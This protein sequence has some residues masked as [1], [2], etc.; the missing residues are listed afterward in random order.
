MSQQQHPSHGKGLEDERIENIGDSRRENPTHTDDHKHDKALDL[1]EVAGGSP[2]LTPENN[3]QVLRKIDLR[4]LPI[5]LAIY[6]LQQVDKSTLSYASVFGIIED[7]GLKGQEYSWLGSVIYLAQLVVQPL[8]A[9]IL[10]K[11]PLGKFLACTTFF[12]GVALTCM[13]PANTFAKLLVCRLF[14]GLFEAGIPPAF[15]ATTQMWYRRYEQPVRLGSWYAM[16]GV[17]NMVGSLITWG[18]AHIQSSVFAPYQIIFIFFGLITVVF[19][20]VVLAFMPDSPSR[21]KFLDEEDKLLAIERLRMNQQGMETNEWKWEHVKEALLDIKSFFWFALMFSISIPSGGITTFGPL[22]VKSF[23]FDQFKTIL[24]NIPFGAVQLVATMGGAWFA[25]YIK[26]KGPVIALLCLPA[27]A[28]CVM[29]LQIP[30]DGAHKGA[31]LAGYY[32]ISVYPGITPLIYSWSAANTAGET[33]KKVTNG[34]LL[35]GQCAGNVVGPNLYTTEEAPLYRRGLLS[36]LALFCVLVVLCGLNIAYLTLLNKKHEKTRVS[37]GKSAKV[38]DHSMY[39]VGAIQADKEENSPQQL[40]DDNAFRDMTD[41]Q[42]EDFVYRIGNAKDNFWTYTPDTE[43]IDLSRGVSEDTPLLTLQTTTNPVRLNPA[44]TAL[45]IIDMQNFFLCPALRR[46]QAES[47]PTAGEKAAQVLIDTGI[48]AA[49][50]HQIRVVWLNWGLTE[51]DLACMPPGLMR[52]FG[53]YRAVHTPDEAKFVSAP[54]S[55]VRE[56]NPSLYR[57]LG[58]D[59]GALDIGNSEVVEGGRVLMRDTWNVALYPPL[60]K[61]YT[62][63]LAIAAAT[64]GASSQTPP[65]PDAIVYKNRMSGL[66]GASTEL[67]VLLKGEGITTLLFAGVNTDQCVGGT[68]MD[69]FSKGEAWEYNCMNCWGFVTSCEALKKAQCEKL[70]KRCVFFEMPKDPTTERIENVESEVRR[71]RE[72]LDDMHS[73]LR[74]HSQTSVVP[75]AGAVASPPAPLPAQQP[76]PVPS[77]AQMLS[78]APGD[79]PTYLDS[80]SVD[81]TGPQRDVLLQNIPPENEYARPAKRKRSGFEVRCDPIADFISKGMITVEYAVSCFQTFF[82]GCDRYIPIFDPEYDTFASVRARSSILLNAICTIGSRIETKPQKADILHSELKKWINVVIQ[83]ER[84]NCLESVQALLVIACYSAER[85]LLLSFATRM[86]LD[87]SLDEAFEELT[88]RLTMKGIGGASDMANS[89]EEENMLMRKSRVWFGFFRV[90]GGKPPGIRMTGNARRC[91]LLLHHPS[92]TVLD[93]RLFSQVE[94]NV[95]RVNINE[96]LGA[97]DT[98]NR[99]DIADFVHEAKVDLDLW[100]DDW[101]RIIR[102]QTYSLEE[103]VPDDT[104]ENSAAAEEERPSLLAALRVQKCWS[105]MMLYC[106]ALRSMGVENI[107]AM[108]A[109]ERNI[110]IMAKASARQHLRLISVE[111]DFYLAKLKYAMDFVWAKCAFCFLLLL[112]LSRLMPEQRE[113]HQELLEHGTRL[114]DE[115][116]KSGSNS[117]TTGNGNV[118]L[119]ILRLSIEKYGRILQENEIGAE[120]QVSGPFWELFD[121]Q[122][123]LQSFV[124]EQFVTEWDFP[125]LNLFYFPTAWQDFFGDYSLAV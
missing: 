5:L 66:W 25:T 65:K 4:L 98:L 95:I 86:A 72:Q 27:I 56:K 79:M 36:N 82:Q 84:L 31:L 43:E 17:V 120:D 45:V 64:S 91:R 54:A 118:Y 85:S 97:R 40:A 8:V 101:L 116:T 37:M 96:T 99:P 87:L 125:G 1:I 44:A 81:I 107:A 26:M 41:W 12:W 73:L 112:K 124:P 29:L 106:K 28:G 71:L 9:Y 15:I 22:I 58:A 67:E 114:L 60:E 63:G 119:H 89:R 80:T 35:I 14:L 50:Q 83:N 49:R 23:G 88:Q 93:L 105:E 24:F 55:M 103:R 39:A 94:L 102:M 62:H 48:P 2:M 92:S 108:S 68:L 70:K 77:P 75:L 6:F 16:N 121:A 38:V 104:A 110:L 122:A 7:V 47:K 113:E 117:D 13:T 32:I 57:G 115:L 11:V 21:A 20:F 46:P 51:E 10:V 30:H 19:S 42:N 111:P 3:A 53:V 18:L 34:I 52:T 100:F 69:A 90:D 109:V 123:D 33:K 78:G 59:L 74:L 61:E 76:C